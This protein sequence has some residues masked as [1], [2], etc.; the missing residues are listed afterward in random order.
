MV[1]E[2]YE[3]LVRHRDDYDLLFVGSSRLNHGIIPQ[4]FD[5]A[6][7]RVTGKNIRSFNAAYDAMWPPE[8]FYY[9][10]RLLALKPK[11]LRWVIFELMDLNPKLR[12]LEQPTLRETYWHD[13][14]RTILAIRSTSRICDGDHENERLNDEAHLRL[15]LKESL[16]LGR[17]SDFLQKGLLQSGKVKKK[18]KKKHKPDWD[19]FDPGPAHGLPDAER[20]SYLRSVA[21]M[22]KP[23]PAEEL[24]PLLMHELDRVVA[25]I[26]AAGAEPIF[27][28]TPTL[29][30]KENFASVP[31]GSTLLKYVDAHKYAALYAPALHYDGWHL[32]EAGAAVFSQIL[33][34]EV[35][36]LLDEG[37][38]K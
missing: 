10:E 36:P 37:R 27:V 23:L 19:G 17:G 12:D 32:N 4:K 22:A 13:L 33:G 31:G 16:N 9:L 15:F 35:A 25:L 20:A 21:T 11:K 38:K 8:S 3:H 6:V 29:N 24:S 7:K 34:D 1:S 18:N 26:R 30:P 2:K 5:A 28:V 14:R